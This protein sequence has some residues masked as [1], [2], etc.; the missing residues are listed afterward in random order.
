MYRDSV[1]LGVGGEWAQGC[2]VVFDKGPIGGAEISMSQ[3]AK[4]METSET[5]PLIDSWYDPGRAWDN[6]SWFVCVDGRLSAGKGLIF[7]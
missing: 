5:S 2:A 7:L 4:G 3:S 6:T 1:S